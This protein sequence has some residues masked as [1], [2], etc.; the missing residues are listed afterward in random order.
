MFE[1]K[2]NDLYRRIAQKISDMIPM[3]WKEIY[4]EGQ[5]LDGAG[6]TYFYFNTPGNEDKYI[7]CLDI[8]DT[9]GA[10]RTIF[11]KLNYELFKLTKELQKVFI[12]Y[13]QEPWFSVIM[14]INSD[15]KFEIKYN[16]VNWYKGGFDQTDILTYFEYKYL[17]IIP[18]DREEQETMKKMDEFAGSQN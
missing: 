16:Y 14:Y 8:R 11:N 3:D 6:G 1:E 13:D 15:G 10:D 12:D 2:L 18:Q 9:Y 4:F 5:V 17:G 7:Y